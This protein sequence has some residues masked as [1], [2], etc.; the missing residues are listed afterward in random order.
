MVSSWPSSLRRA[1]QASA[2]ATAARM[3][4]WRRDVAGDLFAVR[5]EREMPRV[6]QVC[7]RRLQ[8]AAVRGGTLHHGLLAG[9]RLPVYVVRG[10]GMHR[11]S[12]ETR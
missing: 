3:T 4:R 11:W 2:P 12:L 5:L 6:E 7:L 9:Q 10:C 8:V 1:N